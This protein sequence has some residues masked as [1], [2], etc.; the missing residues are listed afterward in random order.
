M[1]RLEPVPEVISVKIPSRLDLLAVLDSVTCAVCERMKFD[2]D[3]TS[4]VSTSVI[5]AG[6]NAIQHGHQR[7]SSR[8]VDVRFS[9]FP[10]R[11]EIEVHD[12]GPG[13]DL[14]KINGDA[15]SSEHLLDPRGRGIFI[16]RTCMDSVEFEFTGSGTVCR[17]MKRLPPPIAPAD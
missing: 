10:D 7:D 3:A 9:L 11:L 8:P 12:T 15:T 6:T 1:P 17:L 2:E 4:Q 13:F 14:S 5:E 16:M